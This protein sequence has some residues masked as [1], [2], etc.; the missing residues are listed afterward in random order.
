MPTVA[1]ILNYAPTASYLAANAVD[2]AKL[3]NKNNLNPILPQQIYALYF[4]LKEIYNRNPVYDG[5]VP[6]ANY[7]WEIMGRYGIQ[8][9]GIFGSGGS[10]TP[11]TPSLVPDPFDFI[12]DGSS[13][14]PTGGS[15]VDLSAYGYIGFDIIFVRGG[16][17]QS[18][19]NTG[20]YYYSYDNTTAILT[21]LGGAA[22]ATESMQIY[23]Q[24]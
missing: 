22:Q 20:G 21:L 24:I 7:L 9:Q 1:E 17:P 12:V 18:I 14:I 23:P 19:N 11:I 16:I 3:F 6:C 10:V 4:I 5:L 15:S 13:L 8:A 2:K